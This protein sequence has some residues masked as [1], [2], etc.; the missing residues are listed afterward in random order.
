[1]LACVERTKGG[2]AHHGQSLSLVGVDQVREDL[3]G[4]GNGDAALVSELVEATLHAQVCKP[5][6]TVLFSYQNTVSYIHVYQ[7]LTAAPPA[8]VPSRQ[9]LISITFFTV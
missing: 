1:M 3:G 9:L 4:C 6:L 8:M 5:V 7:V 2:E